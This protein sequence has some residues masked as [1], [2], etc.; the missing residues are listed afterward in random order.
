MKRL[1][2]LALLIS[3]LVAC[4][5]SLDNLQPAPAGASLTLA[6]E[7]GYSTL[8]LTIPEPGT[9]WLTV[10]GE[11][12]EAN[13]PECELDADGDLLC[14]VGEVQAGYDLPVAGTVTGAAALVCAETCYA[15]RLD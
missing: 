12:L 14:S 2:P 13:A 15:L 10:V 6:P 7:D 3:L 9:A 11:S 5:P 1:I 8:S 4:L